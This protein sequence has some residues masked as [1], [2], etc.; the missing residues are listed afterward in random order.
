LAKLPIVRLMIGLVGVGV[1]WFG[2]DSLPLAKQ[3]WPTPVFRYLQYTLVVIWLF[4]LARVV[5]FQLQL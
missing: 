1:L 4:F 2:L 3:R 5:F